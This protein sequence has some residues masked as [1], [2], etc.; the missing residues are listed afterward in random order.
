[1]YTIIV[2]LETNWKG[3]FYRK[4]TPT[5]MPKILSIS[6]LTTKEN[7]YKVKKKS[8]RQFFI[9]DLYSIFDFFIIG[10]CPVKHNKGD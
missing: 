7:P 5:T 6:W 10:Q 4:L 2:D 9:N 1:M 3:V 8:T